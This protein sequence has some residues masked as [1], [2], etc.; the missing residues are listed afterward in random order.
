MKNFRPFILACL[1][2]ISLVFTACGESEPNI[3]GDLKSKDTVSYENGDKVVIADSNGCDYMVV[4]PDSSTKE[5]TDA[6][7]SINKVI[8][9]IIGTL[10]KLK[11]D[12][13]TKGDLEILVG[14][15]NRPE[16]KSAAEGL[17]EKDF[18]IVFTSSKIAIVGGS[19]AATVE[20]VEYFLDT[21]LSDNILSVDFGT[22]YTYTYV[23]PKIMVGD[24]DLEEFKIY[25][26]DAPKHL[27]MQ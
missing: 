13:G 17:G 25:S 11:T 27:L 5:V 12:Y 24:S 21:Y 8:Y 18:R 2:I 15:T 3:G 10:P 1:L 20:A 4:R 9:G 19:D 16:S 7:V 23:A 22:E 14:N 26:E 6:A